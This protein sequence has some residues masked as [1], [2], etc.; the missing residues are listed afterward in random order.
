[1]IIIKVKN[2][3]TNSHFQRQLYAKCRSF[4]QLVGAKA[5]VKPTLKMCVLQSLQWQFSG[6]Y[7]LILFL[8]T[9]K[10]GKFLNYQEEKNV[11]DNWTKI[12]YTLGPVKYRPNMRSGKLRIKSQI[13]RVTIFLC[14]NIADY[15]WW[16]PVTYFI[17]FTGE[18]LNISIVDRDRTI[19]F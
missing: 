11:P 12:G 4:I 13:V 6:F 7:F 19:F 10:L 3:K 9:L 8:K 5:Y 18:T 2:L 16:Q 1:M 14:K 17:H 15:R